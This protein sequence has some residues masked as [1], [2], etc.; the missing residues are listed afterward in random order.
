[1]SKLTFRDPSETLS[2]ASETQP[3][4][5]P[6]AHRRAADVEMARVLGSAP[7]RVAL[8]SSSAGIAHWKAMRLAAH[9]SSP[10]TCQPIMGGLSPKVLAGAIERL[11]SDSDADVSLD[12]FA[13]DAG[14][15]RFHFCRPFKESTGPSPHVWLRQH[16]LDQAMNLL[17]DTDASIAQVAAELGYASQTAFAAAFGRLSGKTPSEWRRRVSW[18]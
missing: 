7:F 18:Q 12:A 9:S 14:L 8:D 2:A 17:R 5:G 13:S 11:R 15:S 3:D 1:M 6:N 4:S 10:T 16:R